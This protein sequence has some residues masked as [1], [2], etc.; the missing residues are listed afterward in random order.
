M[1]F[2]G[3]ET[4]AEARE[5]RTLLCGSCSPLSANS[6]PKLPEHSHSISRHYHSRKRAGVEAEW[7]RPEWTLWYGMPMWRAVATPAVPKHWPHRAC[8]WP[9]CFCFDRT[10][11]LL[12]ATALVVLHLQNYVS[13]ATFISC[14]NSW[15]CL[16]S[17]LT[18]P[19]KALLLRAADS[20]LNFLLH[21]AQTLLSLYIFFWQ[22]CINSGDWDI[23]G[24]G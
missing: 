3:W 10:L 13:K 20:V 22:H 24:V 11:D 15:K 12:V 7:L 5:E 14:Y 16:N 2:G 21:Q 23:Y 18:F 4:W 19:P 8:S 6:L 1:C 9:V 17:T